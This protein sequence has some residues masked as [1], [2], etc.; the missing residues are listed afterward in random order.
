MKSLKWKAALIVAITLACLYGVFGV[1]KSADE[2]IANWKRNIRLGLDLRGGS[3][4]LLQVQL[5]DA[6]K[7]E[8]NTQIERLKE[9][10][11]KQ[12]IPYQSIDHNDPQ[13]L[14][15]AGD[16]AIQVRGIP[17]EKSQLFRNIVAE[18]LPSWVL[19]PLSSTE[20]RLTLKPT[21]VLALK[22]D[23]VQRAITTIE[24]RIN[25]LGLAEAAVQRRGGAGS[26]A[27]I[28]IS[29]PGLDDPARVKSI[30]QTAA[31]LELYEVKDGPFPRQE[32]ALAKYGGVMPLNTKLMRSAPRPGDPAGEGWYVVT[33]TPVIT[34]RDLRDARPAQDE[35]GK[36]ETAFVLSQEAKGRF[37]RFTE[38]NIGN[39]LAIALDNQIRSAP[40]IQSRIEDQGRIT[41][42]ASHQ[43]ASDLALVLR[44]GSLPAGI[45]YLQEQTVGPSLGADSIRKGLI[46]GAVG[47]V[48][49][50][51]FMLI[52]YAGAG[53]NA[54]VALILNGVILIGCL[55]Y[56]EAVLTLP[57]IAGIIL[58]IGMAVDSNVLIF[59]R[60]REELRA[61]KAT[62]AAVDTGFS[63][64][65]L[66]IIDT[67]VATVVSCAFLFMFGTPAIRGFAV[68]LVIGLVAN[69][70]T[71]V[72]VSRAMF[73]FA[74]ARQGFNPR[75]SIG[76]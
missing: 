8:A 42:A 19:T 39:R 49:V 38:A 60:I 25:G 72:F 7:L 40:T 1:P 61:G 4:L 20:Y 69:V 76:I 53:V 50:V 26:E 10:L 11:G 14:A 37:A 56:L 28:L 57:G 36:W 34:G 66:T 23:T 29:L 18:L 74:L 65:F 70:F 13:T 41:G 67:H 48:F 43:E 54:V 3:M 59:E 12:S 21:E 15:E 16:I 32:D 52:Y 73:Q 27:E 64:A 9:E 63:K 71:S 58:L 31:L 62:A 33:R 35:F 44:A 75:L 47:L 22:E 5:Q 6:F 46:A 51:V 17:A 30:L 2:L 55:A 45:V 24:S 68:T